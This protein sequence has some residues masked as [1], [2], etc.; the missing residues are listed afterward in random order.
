MKFGLSTHGNRS[1]KKKKRENLC[2]F[3]FPDDI[4]YQS[5][6]FTTVL[7]CTCAFLALLQRF[8]IFFFFLDCVASSQKNGK[9]HREWGI[10][11]VKGRGY[12]A[13]IAP[14]I[15]MD[16]QHP[17]YS[18]NFDNLLPNTHFWHLFARFNSQRFDSI[19][20]NSTLFGFGLHKVRRFTVRKQKCFLSPRLHTDQP[21]CLDR[22]SRW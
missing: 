7:L 6:R 20:F 3:V 21:C 10:R 11:R 1:T 5:A 16:L 12:G 13:C 19:R 8:Y 14:D 2:M 17:N 15:F 18:S 22:N 9:Y 4:I